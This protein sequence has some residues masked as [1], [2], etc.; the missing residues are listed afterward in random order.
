MTP[1]LV[2]PS[3]RIR[4]FR[5]F[6]DLSIPRLGRLNLIVG[7]NNTGK[8]SL[9]EA[10][11]L[12]AS[13]GFPQVLW[14]I[15]D[16]R[17]EI[18]TDSDAAAHGSEPDEMPAVWYLFHGYP[19]LSD[20]MAPIMVGPVGKETD[21]VTFAIRWHIEEKA[22][23]GSVHLVERAERLI[24]VGDAIP[25]LTIESGQN[26][27]VVRLERFARGARTRYGMRPEVAPEFRVPC[28][29]VSSSGPDSMNRLGAMWDKV[30]LTPKE[31]DVTDGLRIIVPDIERVAVLGREEY[32]RDRVIMAKT[33][34][35]ARPMPLRNFGE[36]VNR[37]FAMLLALVTAKGGLLLIDEIENGIH[38]SVQQGVW[39]LLFR[40]A[41]QLN[42]QVFASSHSWDCI[43]TFQ[44][45]A[46]EDKQEEG[47]LVSL[48]RTNGDVTATVFDEKE[49]SVATR[50][51]IEVR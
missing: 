34:R 43:E 16:A 9:L 23:D 29:Y 47:V 27:R 38:Y 32:R 10:L 1:K 48:R 44:K 7:K 39:S 35:S 12:Y 18:S 42:V 21:T 11:R 14:E 2:F 49:L 22:Q 31:E 4:G 51:R 17:D 41:R 26:R 50:D 37:V 30:A 46:A 28:V 3:L 20:R 15:L 13:D 25:A 19:V 24:E 40:L 45:A 5:A 8:S 36:G 6:S 33:K